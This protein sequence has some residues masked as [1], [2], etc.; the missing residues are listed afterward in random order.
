MSSSYQPSVVTV[1]LSCTI[2][3]IQ[4]DGRKP[5]ISAFC[6][7]VGWLHFSM[8]VLVWEKLMSSATMGADCLLIGSAVLAQY[9]RVTDKQRDV[10]TGGRT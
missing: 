5:R 7:P 9:H 8:V 2:S 1:S 10:Q 3:E 6:V 4:R